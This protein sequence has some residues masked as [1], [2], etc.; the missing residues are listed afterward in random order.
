MHGDK[1]IKRAPIKI[2][3]PLRACNGSMFTGKK[4]SQN[5][6]FRASSYRTWHI[7]TP[8]DQ[9][10]NSSGKVS[11]LNRRISTRLAH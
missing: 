2:I 8:D 10:K 11:T 6:R 3:K 5:L 1:I 9:Q 7:L 4:W